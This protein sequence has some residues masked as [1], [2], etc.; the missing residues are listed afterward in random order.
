MSYLSALLALSPIGHWR[1]G[2]ASGT[3]AADASGNGHTGTYV[4]SPTLG[5]ASLID[6]DTT[7]TAVTLGSG[8]YVTTPNSA[9]YN[10]AHPAVVAWIKGSSFGNFQMI[11]SQADGTTSNHWFLCFTSTGKVQFTFTST[12]GGDNTADSGTT[13]VDDN[14]RHM[15]VG[16]WDGSFV[17]VFVDGVRVAHV[18]SSATMNTGTG[19]PV[20]IGA[21]AGG[22]FT[23][24]VTIDEVSYLDAANLTDS[25]IANLWAEATSAVTALTASGGRT[26]GGSATLSFS[27]EVDLVASGSRSRSGSAAIN[28]TPVIRASGGRT[29][30]GSATLTIDVLI[31]PISGATPGY[32]RNGRVR[33]GLTVLTIDPAVLPAPTGAVVLPIPTVSNH[34]A[35]PVLVAGQPYADADV[36]PWEPL[37]GEGT[38]DAWGNLR[39]IVAG[40]DRTWFR[41]VKTIV[42]D[43]SDA[44]PGG[45]DTATI[46]FPAITS[47][48]ELGTGDLDWLHADAEIRIQKRNPDGTIAGDVFEGEIGVEEDALTTSSGT[49]P[50]SVGTFHCRGL[51]QV[52]DDWITLPRSKPDPIES[53]E[54]IESLVHHAHHYGFPG[55]MPA[56]GVSG[57]LTGERGEFGAPL[58]SQTIVNALKL[59]QRDDGTVYT[60]AQRRP[61][62][63]VIVER[64]WGGAPDFRLWVGQRGVSHNLTRDPTLAWTAIF[65]RGQAGNQ[66]WENWQYPVA[67]VNP[68]AYPLDIEAGDFF[69][70]G[71]SYS[72]FQPFSDELREH[73]DY[74]IDSQDTYLSSDAQTIDDFQEHI[75]IQVD[76][77]VG[78]Q[79]WNAAFQIGQNANVLDDAYI[80]ELWSLSAV[81]PDLVNGRG[82]IIGDNPAFKPG[83]WRRRE[84]LVDF[85]VLAK[86]TARRSARREGQKTKL[87]YYV[88]TIV[89]ENIDPRE[90]PALDTAS[91]M[92]MEYMGHRGTDRGF[93]VVRCERDPGMRGPRRVTWTVSEKPDD[94]M[95][96]AQIIARR[97]G[98]RDVVHSIRPQRRSSHRTP[99]WVPFDSESGAGILHRTAQTAGLWNGY[100]IPMGEAL[101]VAAVKIIAS[102]PCQMAAAM[103]NRRVTPDML[104]SL[105]GLANPGGG[106]AGDDPWQAN[107]DA[108]NALGIQWST[109]G[110]GAMQG[111]WPHDP[112]IGATLTGVLAD[113]APWPYRTLR[114][115]WGWLLIWTSANCHVSGDPNFRSRA[116]FPAPEM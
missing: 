38:H 67:Y 37:D 21:E 7:D 72:G 40:H 105:P 96:L 82:G 116:I 90:M 73:F 31:A 60:V 3:S 99:D 35:R 93:H 80:R 78:P 61:K 44:D 24:A 52:L 109:G 76:G 55:H 47:F 54:W 33:T 108:L 103:F 104:T 25:A 1:L 46:I 63:L 68:P 15:V 110:P 8:K 70:P 106:A 92:N 16:R 100:Q 56:S 65:G 34:Y 101:D 85:G 20:I 74:D 27:H 50:A 36:T 18:A 77:V 23:G 5:V 71:S 95:T 11:A 6:N 51:W 91:G 32:R 64:S 94:L 111:Y 26:R 14:V 12:I 113:T 79:T 115:P 97:K 43:Y 114:P 66:A 83:Q 13:H 2:E 81:Q 87:P 9:A 62:R 89:A 58:K 84:T 98:V 30:G 53:A 39:V 59:M 107:A 22:A 41:G 45:D 42:A 4:G 75:G 49:D 17:D 28:L 48:D 88:G 29:R 112:A 69:T 57:I 86:P 19:I 102:V 10:I